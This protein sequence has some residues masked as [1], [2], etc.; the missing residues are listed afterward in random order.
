LKKVKNAKAW[1]IGEQIDFLNFF[2][3][4]SVLRLD[5]EA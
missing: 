3:T 2:H 5:A 4:I 1:T